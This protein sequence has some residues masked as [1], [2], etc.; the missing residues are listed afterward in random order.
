MKAPGATREIGVGPS[1]VGFLGC[2]PRTS[3]ISGPWRAGSLQ[4]QLC[5]ASRDCLSGGVH[6]VCEGPMDALGQE[7]KGKLPVG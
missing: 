3:D 6:E 4:M 7:R 2:E 5:G 1:R